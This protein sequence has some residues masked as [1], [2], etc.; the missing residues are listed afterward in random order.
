M[1]F[2]S[3]IIDYGCGHKSKMF[4]DNYI[5]PHHTLLKIITLSWPD[6]HSEKEIAI[7]KIKIQK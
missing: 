6:A 2:V 5:T 7:L 1:Y 4:Y 3:S